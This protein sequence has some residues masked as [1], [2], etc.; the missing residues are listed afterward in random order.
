MS[1][2]VTDYRGHRRALFF[3]PGI[4]LLFIICISWRCINRRNMK[5]ILWR[6]VPRW[7]RKGIWTRTLEARAYTISLRGVWRSGKVVSGLINGR[8]LRRHSPDFPEIPKLQNNCSYL[9]CKQDTTSGKDPSEDPNRNC[10]RTG[11][12]G[13]EQE[14]WKQAFQNNMLVDFKKAW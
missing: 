9:T 7:R 2:T 12:K 8:S 10:R 3:L 11:G 4:I 14:R 13:F 1:A 6:L 5:R